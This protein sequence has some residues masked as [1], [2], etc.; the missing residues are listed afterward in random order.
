[1]SKKTSESS[2]VHTMTKIAVIRI[3]GKTGIRQPIKHA[4]ELIRLY[5]KHH[6]V[7]LNTNPATLGTLRKIKDYVT[8]GELNPEIFQE[9]LTRRGR[10]PGNQPLAESYLKEKLK[11][12]C[13]EFTQHFFA[14]QHTLRDIP[15]LRT[16]FRLLP[17]KGGFERKGIKQP[18]SMG[19]ALGY[20]GQD[21]NILIK[22]ML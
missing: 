6:L 16:Y 17:P 2:R 18:Y 21:I 12:S 15:G 9:L 5:N 22:K 11:L 4:M 19:G 7:I 20:R 1:M 8:W 3:R 10:L 14:A 13:S